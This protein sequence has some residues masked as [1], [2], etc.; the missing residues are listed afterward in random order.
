[1]QGWMPGRRRLAGGLLGACLVPRA[2]G[3]TPMRV[4]H[5]FALGPEDHGLSFRE[6]V[7]QLLLDRSR[8]RFGDYEMHYAGRVSQSRA[9][10]ELAEGRLDV[11]G[12][13]TSVER[14]RLATPIRCC[15]YRGLMGVRTGVGLPERVRAL[16]AGDDT[17]ERLRQL[18][19]G[20]GHDWPIAQAHRDAGLNV[21]GILHFDAGVKRLRLGG[22]DLIS[23][24]VVE[25]PFMCA[26]HGLAMISRWALFMPHPYYFFVA[27]DNPRLAARLTLGFTVALRDGSFDAL[28]R[29]RVLPQLQAAQLDRRL[30]HRF[31]NQDLPAATP[32]RQAA[33][34]H[35]FV[36]EQ[37]ERLG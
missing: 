7:L 32:W 12:T 19:L 29:R 2:L 16:D 15:L 26:K 14:E 3:A 9:F 22:M 10:R 4:R 35:P 20:V 8:E 24:S 31:P 37:M 11:I 17:L 1:M 33:L 25:A 27:R 23:Q 34:W 21:V 18:R 28:F 13:A 6:E 36:L 30:I 5:N